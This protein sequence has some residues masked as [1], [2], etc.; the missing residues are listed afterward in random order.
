MNQSEMNDRKKVTDTINLYDYIYILY[1]WKRFIVVNVLLLC[2]GITALTLLMPN[3]YKSDALLLPPE[4]QT[5]LSGLPQIARDLIPMNVMGRFGMPHPGDRYLAVLNSRTVME[6]VVQQFDLIQVYKQRDGSKEKT[7][8]RL[9]SNTNFKANDDGTILVEVFDRDPERASRMVEYFTRMLDEILI[10]LDTQEARNNREFIQRRHDEVRRN[11]KAVE[12]SLKIF[13][14]KYGIYS[15]A[16]QTE[17]AIKAA[18]EI[19]SFIALAEVELGM[20]SRSI[21]ADNPQ[22]RAKRYEIEELGKKVQEMKF[23]RDDWYADESLSLFVPFRDVPELGLQ[24]VRLYR[25]VEIQSKILEFILPLYEQA[26]IEEQKDIPQVLI[27]DKPI[28]AERKTKPYRTIIILSTTLL[29]LFVFTFFI[30]FF[31][32]F[33]NKPDRNNLIE[34]KLRT[35]LF[36]IEK[37]YR[38]R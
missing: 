32:S 25:E 16:D 29:G 7:I 26:K 30:L 5:S 35:I 14:E 4:G 10:N 18:A 12:D 11:L 1:K 6:Y 2:I 20:M 21:Q 37:I 36:R 31:E 22:V 23:G 24:F 19:Q 28:P 27:L 13:Q 33:R 8:K 17:V 9:R 34:D 15:L 3:W 38:I